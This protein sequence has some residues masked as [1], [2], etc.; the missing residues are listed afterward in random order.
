MRARLN[1]G[2][3]FASVIL[4]WPTCIL[5]QEVTSRSIVDALSQ[6]S[7]R[8]LSAPPP[9]ADEDRELFD[10]LGTATTRKIVVE[11]RHEIA[12]AVDKYKMPSIDLDV[13]F[14]F[15]SARIAGQAVPVLVELG[16]ALTGP[17]LHGRRFLVTGHTDAKGADDYNLALSEQRALAVK[18]YM[19]QTFGMA[20]ADLIA[21]GYGEEMLKNAADPE[22]GENRRV[23][24]IAVAQ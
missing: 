16:T 9:L 22:A 14:D 17:E 10:A 1:Y 19:V 21:V 2:V 11:A 7:T 4:L 23:T 3:V 15:D 18:S 5:G 6:P 13:Y 8:S 24:I 20:A 12:A